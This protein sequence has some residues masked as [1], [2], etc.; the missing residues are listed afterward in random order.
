MTL[1]RPYPTPPLS[2][3][4]LRALRVFRVVAEAGGLTAAE[5]RLGMERSTVSRHLK[6]LEERLGGRLCQR[7]P[8]GFELTEF[9]REV[10]AAAA[11]LGDAV[12]EARAI[13]SGRA[14]A[15]GGELRIGLADNCLSNPEARVIEALG[16]FVAQAPDAQVRLVI[17]APSELRRMLRERRLHGCVN[18]VAADPRLEGD[19][20]FGEEFRLYARAAPDGGSPH[21]SMLEALGFGMVQRDGEGLEAGVRSPSLRLSRIAHAEGI[22]AV[23]S[24]VAC[25]AYV[26]MMPTHV[27]AAMAAHGIVEVAGAE[28]QRVRVRF[29]FVVERDRAPTRALRLLRDIFRTTHSARRSWRQANPCP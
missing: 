1:E 29:G 15:I 11:A 5:S 7:G 9:G 24:L 4:D 17:G 25:G 18:G 12:H 2:E 23:A 27:A 14:A 28:A 22:E 26:G 8:R 21:V 10:F 6:G 20:L 3:R 16:A 13:L 19:E